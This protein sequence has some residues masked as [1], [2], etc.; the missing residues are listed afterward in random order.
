[1]VLLS[2]V[3]LCGC[4]P[5]KVG[6]S[7]TEERIVRCLEQAIEIGEKYLSDDDM[8]GQIALA[9]G[10]DAAMKVYDEIHHREHFEAFWHLIDE[11]AALAVQI[12]DPT[13]LDCLRNRVLPYIDRLDYLT[14]EIWQ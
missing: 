8:I 6:P 13:E 10:T 12:T 11:A 3:L 5:Q 2:V 14:D 1:M 7:A 4:I 9:Q